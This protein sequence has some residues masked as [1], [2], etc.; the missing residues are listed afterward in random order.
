MCD[1]DLLW[2]LIWVTGLWQQSGEQS[3]S[4]LGDQSS[5]VDLYSGFECAVLSAFQDST[6]SHCALL[7]DISRC[8]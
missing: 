5:P 6:P 1:F 7:I 2:V 8:E 4:V 3:F